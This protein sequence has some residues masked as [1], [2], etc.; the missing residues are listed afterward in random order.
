MKWIGFIIKS[1]IMK[2]IPNHQHPSNRITRQLTHRTWAQE[3][4]AEWRTHGIFGSTLIIHFISRRCEIIRIFFAKS[5]SLSLTLARSFA[6]TCMIRMETIYKPHRSTRMQKWVKWMRC[7]CVW[8]RWKSERDSKRDRVLLLLLSYIHSFC[9]LSGCA[10]CDLLLLL[11]R[12]IYVRC[13]DDILP[14]VQW[15]ISAKN[16]CQRMPLSLTSTPTHW[17]VRERER[18]S[19]KRLWMFM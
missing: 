7:V 5:L 17:N 15:R 11:M 1:R 18:E 14:V 9:W 6:I 3:T 16:I 8:K 12:V 2:T 19:S 13:L 10:K 4:E